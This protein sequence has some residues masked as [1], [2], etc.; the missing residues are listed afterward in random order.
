MLVLSLS[1]TNLG[2]G[3][4]CIFIPVLINTE[5]EEPLLG[6]GIISQQWPTI[7]QLPVEKEFHFQWN[8]QNMKILTVHWLLYSLGSLHAHLQ[9]HPTGWHAGFPHLAS[10][11]RQL[12]EGDMVT[13]HHTLTGTP[14]SNGWVLGRLPFC[15]QSQRPKPIWALISNTTITEHQWLWPDP[16]LVLITLRV[17]RRPPT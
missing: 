13:P 5:K 2:Q 4:V 1:S 14:D 7:F 9:S 11:G 10:P 8:N 15:A 3:V 6:E 16:H 17:H 12:M